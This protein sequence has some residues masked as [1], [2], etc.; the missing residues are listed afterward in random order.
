MPMRDEEEQRQ[1]QQNEQWIADLANEY[2][3][4][5]DKTRHGTLVGRHLCF[6]IH[7]RRPDLRYDRTQTGRVDLTDIYT[8]PKHEQ[9]VALMHAIRS[10]L[11]DHHLSVAND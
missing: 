3:G 9:H 7:S 5:S 11:R 10:Q 6:P 2:L 4:A 8:R 1:K